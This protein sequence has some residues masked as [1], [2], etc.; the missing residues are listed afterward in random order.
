[1]NLFSAIA[2]Y[3]LLFG[4]A[5]RNPL[6]VPA[7][8]LKVLSDSPLFHHK[9][10]NDA[11]TRPTISPLDCLQTRL[12]ATAPRSSGKAEIELAILTLETLMTISHRRSCGALGAG[13]ALWL[14]LLAKAA[15]H[16]SSQRQELVRKVEL[17]PCTKAVSL[18]RWSSSAEYQNAMRRELW[19]FSTPLVSLQ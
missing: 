11:E 2:I 16:R 18:K 17:L 6:V 3:V 19:F 10:W 4:I 14:G 13:C 1:M 8:E 9:V 12:L 15:K 7:V 5:A